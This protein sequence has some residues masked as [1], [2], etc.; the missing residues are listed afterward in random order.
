MPQARRLKVSIEEMKKAVEEGK[1]GEKD[2]HRKW[3]DRDLAEK[4]GAGIHR[5]WEAIKEAT[6]VGHV[7]DLTEDAF[8]DLVQSLVGRDQKSRLEKYRGER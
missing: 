1:Q 6:G 4:T 2:R 3:Q 7:R 8:L 5:D